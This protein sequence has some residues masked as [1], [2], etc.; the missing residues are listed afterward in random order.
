MI[1]HLLRNN[2]AKLYPSAREDKG[3][4]VIDMQWNTFDVYYSPPHDGMDAFERDLDEDEG[5]GGGAG[6]WGS[7]ER[8]DD[9]D[10]KDTLGYTLE[11]V[12]PI[13]R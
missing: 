5:G 1:S 4:L 8:E 3:E 13:N 6:I 2:T 7:S 9:D 10:L 11:D 12:R